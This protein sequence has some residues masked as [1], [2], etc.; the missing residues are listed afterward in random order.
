MPFTTVLLFKENLVPVLKK[1]QTKQSHTP[2]QP[3]NQSALE[4]WIY[5]FPKEHDLGI[6]ICLDP[7][8][9][10]FK[11]GTKELEVSLW[12][13][14][15]TILAKIPVSIFTG[16]KFAMETICEVQDVV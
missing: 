2:P 4:K 1:A 16:F 7:Y 5:S 10:S 3:W 13:N 11:T 12:N 6:W 9:K 15:A 8:L 14:P